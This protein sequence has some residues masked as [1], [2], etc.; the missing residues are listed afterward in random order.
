MISTDCLYMGW[1]WDMTLERKYVKYGNGNGKDKRD[2]GLRS[3]SN[4][5]I[6]G[7]CFASK[8]NVTCRIISR[9]FF[10]V[11]PRAICLRI[12]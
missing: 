9:I 4:V 10:L 11:L 6:K 3:N 12:L 7:L 8:S 1:H 5:F 2:Q